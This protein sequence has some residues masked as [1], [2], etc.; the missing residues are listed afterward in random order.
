M[1]HAL[2]RFLS[3]AQ[4]VSPEQFD[5]LFRRRALIAE[6]TSDDDEAAYVKKDEFLIHL[7]RRE[8]E[9]VFDSVDEHAPFIGDDWWPDHTRHLEL[10]TKHCTPEFLTAIRRL[11][12]DDYKDYRV[13]CCV[14]DD[15]MNEDTY[16]G[17]MVFS[18]KDLLVEAKL[19]QA[20]QRQ[21]DA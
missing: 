21:A 7:I 5:E 9:R 15:Y 16:I 8:A 18:A 11:L 19:S 17:S 3:N 13:Q 20:L 12:T 10:T 14:Y 2:S 1:H 4:V 6:F